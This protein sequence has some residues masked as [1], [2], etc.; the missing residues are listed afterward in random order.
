MK[1]IEEFF[2]NGFPGKMG[3]K[4]KIG[5]KGGQRW[6]EWSENGRQWDGGWWVCDG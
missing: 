5:L 1:K 6:V 3:E 4:W 2:R